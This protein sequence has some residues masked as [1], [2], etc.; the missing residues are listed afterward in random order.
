[1]GDR[2][3]ETPT[4]LGLGKIKAK[5]DKDWCPLL[6]ALGTA[7]TLPLF[8]IAGMSTASIGKVHLLHLLAFV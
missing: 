5:A 4:T 3:R 8:E 6:N 7:G 2:N 1:M